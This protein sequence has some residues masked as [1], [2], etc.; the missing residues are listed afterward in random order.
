ML[1]FTFYVSSRLTKTSVEEAY[2]SLFEYCRE[3][4]FL[5]YDPFDGL[6]SPIFRLLPFTGLKIAR[7]GFQQVVK[8][9]A[10]NLRP[11]LRI[12]PGENAKALALFALGEIARF[13]TTHAEAHRIS[14]VELLARLERQAIRADDTLA[15][16]YNF[17]WQSRAFFAPR[18]TAT[19]VPTAFAARAFA[20]GYETFGD[21]RFLE[22]HSAVCRFIT[23]RLERPVDSAEELSFS[24]TP[25]DR[26]VI[27]NASLLAAETLAAGGRI[28]GNEDY[29]QL[30]E[31]AARF[32][33]GRQQSDGSWKYGDEAKFGWI[34]N[35]HTAYVLESLYRIDPQGN[36]AAISKGFD[37]WL[38][39]FFLENGAPRYFHNETYPIDIHSAAVAIATLVELSDFD[40]RALPLAAKVAE[41]TIGN[42][43]DAGGFFYYQLRRSRTVK[44]PFIRW[45]QAWMAYA[46]A[47]LAEN[48]FEGE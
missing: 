11:V 10:F 24:Y 35:F 18:G 47:R 40:E 25:M 13:R 30:A 39:T 31:R 44:T 22:N 12:K 6:G 4:D 33:V 7:L 5:G 48:R 28:S 37:Y 19:I 34:D 38:N 27:Y 32:V 3:R 41:W 9:S 26:S 8:R 46:L 23:T 36:R 43:R 20:E 21:E 1:T 42:M 16:G 2:A 17:D 45:S 29:L 15:F 14:A